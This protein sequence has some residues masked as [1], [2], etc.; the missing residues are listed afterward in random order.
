[1]EPRWTHLHLRGQFLDQERLRKVRFQPPDGPRYAVPLATRRR[2]LPQEG[3]VLPREKSVV[4]LLVDQWRKHFEGLRL[5]QQLHQPIKACQHGGRG[6][7]QRNSPHRGRLACRRWHPALHQQLGNAPFVQLQYQA[8]IRRL[9]AGFDG[10][11]H[12]WQVQRGEQE[13][14][15]VVGIGI[16]TQYSALGTLESQRDRGLHHATHGFGGSVVAIERKAWIRSA[17]VLDPIGP[18]GDTRR[19]A[20]AHGLEFTGFGGRQGF[21][22]GHACHLSGA[23]PSAWM[24]SPSMG[25]MGKKMLGSFYPGIAPPWNNP[26][27]Y[28]GA[29]SMMTRRLLA[30][31]AATLALGLASPAMAQNPGG[32]YVRWAELETDL[33]K[34]ATFGQAA[35]ENMAATVLEPGVIAIHWAAEKGNP[36]RIRVLEIYR[37]HA[38]YQAHLQSPHFKRFAQVSQSTLV[39]RRVYD[40]EPITL[41]SKPQVTSSPALH[42]RVAELEIDAKHLDAYK[43]AVTQEIE[44][45]IER[46]PGVLAIYSVA[47]KERPAHL[48]F[49]EIYA[50][51]AAYRAHIESAH[52]K[53]YVET[54]KS[55]ITARKLYE[56]ESP[57]LGMKPVEPPSPGKLQ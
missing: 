2:Q 41:G 49:F 42:V 50:D 24:S 26:M 14:V 8:E 43:T 11:E 56:M 30:A 16:V 48:R 23:A 21:G 4:D 28:Q 27:D 13:T 54:T 44:A 32:P 34:E 40:T 12:D 9:L 29:L 17:K 57:S 1:M 55:M 31:G 36:G 25:G 6:A 18:P 15:L 22:F 53:K 39:A 10:L 3:A 20:G 5:I 35:R 52:F 46:E 33:A 51:E 38:A 47:L 37:D 7:S 45:S 19:Q